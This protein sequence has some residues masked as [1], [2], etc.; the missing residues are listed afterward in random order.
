MTAPSQTD[1]LLREDTEHLVHP[2]QTAADTQHPTL[3]VKGR[4]DILTD[5]EG[6][7]YIDGLSCLWNVNVGHGRKEL[8]EAASSQME[9]LAFVTNYAGATNIPAIQLATKL[10][11]I[12]KQSYPH[13]AA[14]YFTTGGAESNEAAFK[15]ARWYWKIAGKPR[16]GEGHLA[17]PRLSRRHDGR[18]QRDGHGRLP[19]D[20][21]SAGA[22]LRAGS[23]AAPLSLGRLRRQG[24]RCRR[25][26]GRGYR[27]TDPAR[28]AADRWPRS[29]PSR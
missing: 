12:A 25:R 18:R 16:E 22:Q 23:A 24:R 21:R 9:Q 17:R 20:V 1:L 7:D 29:S 11:A 8:A 4:G 2:L 28:G 6:K 13:I 15:T 14:V 3:F 26:S 19:Q 10:V 27:A 5:I